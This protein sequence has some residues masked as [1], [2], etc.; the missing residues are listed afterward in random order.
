MS[1]SMT[2]IVG[3]SPEFLN[4]LHTARLVAATASPVLITGES[5]TGKTLL[6]NLIHHLSPRRQNPCLR[7]SAT[8]LS[9]GDEELAFFGRED[10]PPQGRIHSAR[11]GTIIL[12]NVERLSPWGQLR[13]LQ[14]LDGPS[15]QGQL[16]VH[17]PFRDFRIIAT[18]QCH[19]DRLLES[20]HLRQDL[21]YALNV[22]RLNLPSL[23]QRRDDIR[24]LLNHFVSMFAEHFQLAPP[25][26]TRPVVDRLVNYPWPGN[27][28]ELRNFAERVVVLFPGRPLHTENLPQEIRHHNSHPAG[29]RRP[30]IDLPQGGLSIAELERSLIQQALQRTN[31]NRSRAA[32]L[33]GLTRDTLIY[34]LKKYAID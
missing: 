5:G 24:P 6:C 4:V 17:E 15:E 29:S 10:I 14:I 30:A 20:G 32:R 16:C 27:L 28:R 19:F 31:G 18:T 11:G 26:F 21:F 13:L 3:S 2:T 33:L 25:R 1:A 12:D 22:V 7:I 23:R 34:R 9:P 8:D